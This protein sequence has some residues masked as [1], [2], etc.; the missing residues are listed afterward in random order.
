MSMDQPQPY[1]SPEGMPPPPRRGMSMGAKVLLILGGLFLVLIVICCGG[2]VVTTFWAQSYAKETF[3]QD[4]QVVRR[5]TA[6]IAEIDI[7]EKLRPLVSMNMKVPF[8]GQRMMTIVA[9]GDKESDSALALAAFAEAMAGQDRQQFELQLRQM[10][11]QE[12]LDKQKAVVPQ[13]VEEKEISVR[14][15]PQ[16]FTFIRGKDAETGKPRLEVKGT[17]EGKEGASFFQFSGDAETYDEQ[18][19]VKVIESIR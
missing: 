10:L 3:S 2:L 1:T 7:P 19:I 18:Q 9:Y 8:T 6:E 4:P 17:F 16:K 15:Q 11:D 5:V 12:G 13:E 14:G